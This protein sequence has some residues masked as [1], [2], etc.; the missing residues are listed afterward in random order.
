VS[1]IV[2]SATFR[3]CLT[4]A[5]QQL[6][7]ARPASEDD[8]RPVLDL[9]SWLSWAMTIDELLR[10]DGHYVAMRARDPGGQALL[11]L[12]HAWNVFKHQGQNLDDLL[13]VDVRPDRPIVTRAYNPPRSHV[14][15]A[16]VLEA[17][18]KPFPD[19]PPVTNPRQRH[20]HDE[21]A[22]INHLATKPV[23]ATAER[24]HTFLLG[25]C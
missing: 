12:R 23:K 5:W 15:V 11:G 19:L 17:Q 9:A 2:L 14:I 20:P 10:R 18:W 13:L 7:S 22:Y 6:E 24:I 8:P 21:Q 16:A 1:R 25:V 3:A 4:L